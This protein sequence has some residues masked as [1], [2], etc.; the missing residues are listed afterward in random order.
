MDWGRRGWT[1]TLRPRDEARATAGEACCFIGAWG[2]HAPD[3]TRA[4]VA[5][6]MREVVLALS[7]EDDGYNGWGRALHKEAGQPN[8]HVE[9][10]GGQTT[11]VHFHLTIGPPVV[12]RRV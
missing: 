3:F 8:E 1:A 2:A 11:T 10:N 12:L 5:P 7:G 4:A 9:V 6:G